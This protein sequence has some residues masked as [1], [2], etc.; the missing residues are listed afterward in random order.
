MHYD[1]DYAISVP[2]PAL[3][4]AETA[5]LDAQIGGWR[6]FQIAAFN[7]GNGSGAIPWIGVNVDLNMQG[8]SHNNYELIYVGSGV[9]TGGERSVA[10]PGPPQTIQS[11]AGFW[12]YPIDQDKKMKDT[13]ISRIPPYIALG[14]VQFVGYR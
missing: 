1:N 6:L 7:L 14:Y 13:P 2:T 10:S 4:A 3:T 5:P 12:Q 11:F 9:A 8:G